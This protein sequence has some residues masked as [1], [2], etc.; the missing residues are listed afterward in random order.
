LNRNHLKKAASV[1]EKAHRPGH[2]CGTLIPFP[3]GE[4]MTATFLPGI[5]EPRSRGI[6]GIF[7]YCK[8]GK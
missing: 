2:Q 1:P 5:R 3:A 6:F 7:Y 4:T 8:Y